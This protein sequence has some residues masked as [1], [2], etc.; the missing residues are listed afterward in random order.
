MGHFLRRSWR[1]VASESQSRDRQAAPTVVSLIRNS[2]IIATERSR[3]EVATHKKGHE[4]LKRCGLSS[5]A[6]AL[7]DSDADA[8]DLQ[9]IER[10]SRDQMEAV[11]FPTPEDQRVEVWSR[12]PVHSLCWIVNTANTAVSSWL[13]GVIALLG[14][15]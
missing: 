9:S 14:C 7:R 15:C 3:R 6:P 13:R 5:A 11:F 8:R 12:E 2:R 4:W 10:L 1:K